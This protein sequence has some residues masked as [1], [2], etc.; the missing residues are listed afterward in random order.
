VKE[1]KAM[2]VQTSLFGAEEEEVTVHAVRPTDVGKTIEKTG[3][4]AIAALHGI[5][6]VVAEALMS[7]VKEER[8]VE[9]LK[10]LE[11]AGVVCVQSEGSA[12]SQVFEGK[13]F[14]LTG[15]LPKLSREEAR[16][17][18]KDRGGN[19]SGSVSKKTD[20]VLAG[21]E[22]GQKLDDAKKFNVTIIDEAQFRKMLG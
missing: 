1:K 18:I 12:I 13:T 7:W 3:E 8:S 9:L 22:A 4:E 19:V 6:D 15:A 16:Q 2:G 5:G 21:D 10:K 11:E 14:V 17:M 20:Y